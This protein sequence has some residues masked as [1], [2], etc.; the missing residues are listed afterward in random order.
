MN[1]PKTP[2]PK[3]TEQGLKLIQLT[4]SNPK[5]AELIERYDS[6]TAVGMGGYE[7]ELLVTEITQEVGKGLME[8]WTHLTQQQ[9]VT[10]ELQSNPSV[11]NGKKKRYFYTSFGKIEFD[12]Q[13]TQDPASG[14]TSVPFFQKTNLQSCGCSLLLQRRIVDFSSERSF[15]KTA[16]A[17]TEHY[18]VVIPPSAIRNITFKIGKEAYQFNAH[19]PTLQQEAETLIAQI[20]GSM[21]PTVDY[22]ETEQRKKKR[23]CSWKEI[24][25]CCVTDPKNEITRYGVTQGTPFEAGCMMYQTSQQQGLGDNTHIHGVADGAPW[26]AQQYEVQFGAHHTFLLDFY[27]AAEYLAEVARE[28]IGLTHEAWLETKKVQ[29]KEGNSDLVI[30]ELAK[31]S[32]INGEDSASAKA[33][34]YFSNREDQLSYDEAIEKRLPI[35]SGEVESGHRSVLQA[36]LKKPG[37][38]WEIRNAEKMAQLKA[39]QSNVDWGD[40]WKKQAA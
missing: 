13:V 35:G 2:E 40:F 33:H 39:M 17:I 3:I 19:Q 31:L 6:E 5:L 28:D 23:V 8:E 9:A 36:R 18:G 26:I 34:Q 15:Q 1:T 24:R 14:K 11:K 27:H 38:W 12:A 32:L 25:L 16:T 21:I 29:L 4:N 7:A 30:E 10:E 20:D 37:A 22:Q